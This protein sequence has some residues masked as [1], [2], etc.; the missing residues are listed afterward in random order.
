MCKISTL[1]GRKEETT[2]LIMHMQIKKIRLATSIGAQT[3]RKVRFLT[4]ALAWNVLMKV[5][6]IRKLLKVTP[7]TGKMYVYVIVIFW[8]IHNPAYLL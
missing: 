5:S 7:N 1:L 2:S 6:V 3:F 8:F 4:Q